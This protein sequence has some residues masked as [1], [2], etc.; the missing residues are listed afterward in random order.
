MVV[1]D[2]DVVPVTVSPDEAQAPLVVDSNAV[3]PRAI[4]LQGFEPVSGKRSEI[5][6]RAR[7]MKHF[8]LPLGH[9]RYGFESAA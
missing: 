3:L 6:E 7:A 2:L 8:E 5:F 9:A 1:D 4:S